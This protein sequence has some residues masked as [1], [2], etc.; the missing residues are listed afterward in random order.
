MNILEKIS[1][2]RSTLLDIYKDEWNIDV[3]KISSKKK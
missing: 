1:K 3:N 2:S